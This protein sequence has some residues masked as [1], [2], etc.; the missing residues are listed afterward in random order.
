MQNKISDSWAT[1]VEGLLLEIWGRE[2]EGDRVEV[3]LADDY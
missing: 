1:L 3:P 2:R